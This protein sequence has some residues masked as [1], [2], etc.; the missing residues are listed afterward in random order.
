M[1]QVLND[2]RPPCRPVRKSGY[3]LDTWF[4]GQIR[5]LKKGKDYMCAT[6]AIANQLRRAARRRGFSMTCYKETTGKNEFVVIV[7][8]CKS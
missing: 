8:K 5:R 6:L 7:P 2:Y 3:P 4:D 1:P